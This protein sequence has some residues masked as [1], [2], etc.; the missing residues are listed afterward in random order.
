MAHETPRPQSSPSASG[1]CGTIEA[2]MVQAV[3][4]ILSTA[5]S[6]VWRLAPHELKCTTCSAAFRPKFRT[7]DG[8]W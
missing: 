6:V 3:R 2:P 7:V 1:P 4:S 5:V 8:S